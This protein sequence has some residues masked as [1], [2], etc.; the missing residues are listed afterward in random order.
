[1]NKEISDEGKRVLGAML[2]VASH[3]VN[4]GEQSLTTE[5]VNFHLSRSNENTFEFQESGEGY[6]KYY[7]VCVRNEKN[8]TYNTKEFPKLKSI[9][10]DADG[11]DNWHIGGEIDFWDGIKI[12]KEHVPGWLMNIV[13]VEDGVYTLIDETPISEAELDKIVDK[14]MYRAN[15]QPSFRL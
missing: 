3:I 13:E 9:V 15:G 14:V 10:Q 8:G 6:T 5:N 12:P 2:Y 1:M 7:M 11:E 4:T